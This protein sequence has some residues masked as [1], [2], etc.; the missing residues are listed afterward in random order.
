MSHKNIVL[1]IDPNRGARF[2]HQ[3]YE[4]ALIRAWSIFIQAKCIY[5][6]GFNANSKLFGAIFNP[7]D[8]LAEAVS[9]VDKFVFLSDFN[10]ANDFGAYFDNFIVGNK[11]NNSIEIIGDL[12]SSPWFSD[13]IRSSIDSQCIDDG[14]LYLA[15]HLRFSIFKLGLIKRE[16]FRRVA[17]HVRRG[18]IATDPRFSSRLVDIDYY[19]DVIDKLVNLSGCKYENID[20]YSTPDLDLTPFRGLRN[21]TL[22][23]GIDEVSAFCEMSS[24]AAIVG[25][26]SGFSFAAHLTSS[27]AV[28]IHEK[29]W[30]RYSSTYA[31]RDVDRFCEFC[32]ILKL[33]Q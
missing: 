10:C 13:Y 14:L 19:I 6:Q 28:L 24:H 11:S 8:S 4:V 5:N 16:C 33:S 18:D 21:V 23:T 15:S 25:S 20:L 9:S 2:G 29:D 17:V 31:F 30:N 27:G 12:H 7:A 22:R 3:F 26:P 1:R 32:K